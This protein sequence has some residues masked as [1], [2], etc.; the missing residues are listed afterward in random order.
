MDGEKVMEDRLARAT[1]RYL[2][3]L[4]DALLDVHYL[5]NEVRIEYLIESAAA[6]R[7]P[8]AK[9]LA[10][11]ARHMASSVRERKQARDAGELPPV[12]KERR[13]DRARWRTPGSVVSGSSTSRPV[14]TGSARTQSP[15]TSSTPAP[16]EAGPRSSCEG[17]SRHTSCR[18]RGCGSQITSP[19]RSRP[20]TRSRHSSRT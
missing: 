15:A 4:R 1:R 16:V 18:I 12:R 3:L 8:I 14:S 7:A 11:P 5:E 2:E 20:M 17:F 6:G 13:M 9:K 19:A 10:N